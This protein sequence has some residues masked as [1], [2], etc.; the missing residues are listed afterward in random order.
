CVCVMFQ[1]YFPINQNCCCHQH[2]KSALNGKLIQAFWED[3]QS[4]LRK[5]AGHCEAT[6]RQASRITSQQKAS[7][8]VS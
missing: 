4:G 5:N 7:T 3:E 8:S 2:S 6:L 1:I